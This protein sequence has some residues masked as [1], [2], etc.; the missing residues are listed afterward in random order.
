MEAWPMVLGRQGHPLQSWQR[1]RKGFQRLERQA[2]L[3]DTGEALWAYNVGTGING[4]PTTFT[5][6]GKQYVAIVVGP[7]GGG[8]WP[9]TYGDWFK[10][11]SK[12]GG[13][14]VFGL[15]D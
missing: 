13:L 3:D 10:K 8:I 12:G 14:I 5:A 6:G 15:E 11:Q 1:S 2:R 7:G 9:V 4:N